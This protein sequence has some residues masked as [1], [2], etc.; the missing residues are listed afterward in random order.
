M[1]KFNRIISA[2]LALSIAVSLCS[3]GSSKSGKKKAGIIA[4]DPDKHVELVWYIRSS[5]PTGFKE[6]M[7]KANE[8]V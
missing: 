8:Y 1:K 5:E 7:E 4:D 6:V 3:C 2:A